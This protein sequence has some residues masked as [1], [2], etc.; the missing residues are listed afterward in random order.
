MTDERI[1]IVG[2][3]LSGLRTAE[4][5]RRLG[6]TGPVTLVSGEAHPPY[7]RPPLSKSLLTEDEPAGPKPLR[8][9][10]RYPE[11]GL[12][13]RLSRHAVA[14]DTGRRELTLDGGETLP[15][16]RLVIATGA[17]AR[18]ITAFTRHANVHTLRTWE[19][20]LRLR[21]A[22]G[23]ASHVT[24]IGGGVLGCEITASARARGVEV[25]LLEG[26]DQPLARVLGGAVGA[27]VA[28]LHRSRGVTVR[29]SAGVTAVRGDGRADTVV[30]ADGT[31]IPTDLVVL[32]VGSVPNTEWLE[33]SGLALDDGVLCDRTGATSAEGVF[34]AGDVARMPHPD[35]RGTIRLEHWTGAGDTAALVA[36]NLLAA[37]RDRRPLTEVP[38]FW[39]D[40]YGSRIQC[41]GVPGAGAEPVTAEGSLES[42]RFLVLYAEDGR[43]TGAAAMDMPAALA[44]C[45]TAV[46]D[47][48]PLSAVLDEAPW[49][50]RA[51]A[52]A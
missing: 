48:R 47:R 49:E 18:T 45:R 46:G 9:P 21:A 20:C 31:A 29:C 52:R 14:L 10:G 8:D 15:F 1:V 4:R 13:L 12:D 25:D 30:L 19:D 51:P 5:L 35:G 23:S 39:S 40:Q 16:G 34:A 6:H 28:A 38:Y 37:P 27:S 3:G 50:R 43:V 41:L 32:A 42:G 22:L 24:V 2:G 7:D 26:L 36:A 33:G 44:R 11:L 17:R